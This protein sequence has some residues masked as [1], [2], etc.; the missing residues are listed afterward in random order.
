MYQIQNRYSE[1]IMELRIS[2]E[3]IAVITFICIQLTNQ[4]SLGGTP[5]YGPNDKIVLL[6]TTNFQS[7]ICGSST[8]HGVVTVSTLLQH[9]K[10]WQRMCTVGGESW[11][12][13][14][15]TAPWSTTWRPAGS[16][17]SW[18]IPQSNSSLQIHLLGIWDIKETAG[19][20]RFL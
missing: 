8:A 4:N 9:L 19:I 20:K 17:K 18:V 3:T 7:T 5:L 2:L 14:P 12:W 16:M 13:P 10:S 6:N 15:S 11:P 1:A